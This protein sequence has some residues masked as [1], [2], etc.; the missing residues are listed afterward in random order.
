MKEI[1]HSELHEKLA[2]SAG[3]DT[4]TH[5]IEYGVD[6]QVVGSLHYGVQH[7]GEAHHRTHITE[8]YDYHQNAPDTRGNEFLF[9]CHKSEAYFLLKRSKRQVTPISSA[10]RSE[11]VETQS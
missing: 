11:R 2:E 3:N 9:L 10:W 1:H 8:D 7:V 6:K 4:H 5:K